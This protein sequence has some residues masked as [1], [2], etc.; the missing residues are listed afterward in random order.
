MNFP[1][2]P[3]PPGG[4]FT[5][6]ADESECARVGR[7]LLLQEAVSHVHYWTDYGRDLLVERDPKEPYQRSWSAVAKK[8]RAYRDTFATLTD[9]QRESVL[10]LLGE[11][12]TGSVFSTLCTFDQ[13][14]H[15]EAEI[16]VRD[17]VCG[18]GSRTFTIAPAELDLHDEFTQFLH[19]AEAL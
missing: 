9:V 19:E 12:I 10:R 11:C 18:K 15:G 17:G 1:N 14:P 3:E 16:R 4:E 5:W 8:D 6:P 2:P 7:A 13:F